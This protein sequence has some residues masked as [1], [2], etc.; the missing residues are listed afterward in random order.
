MKRVKGTIWKGKDCLPTIMFGAKNVSFRR[1]GRVSISYVPFVQELIW[2]F[3]QIPSNSYLVHPPYP[4]IV[5]GCFDTFCQTRKQQQQQQQQQEDSSA[6][7]FTEPK[8]IGQ[9]RC[10]GRA[11]TGLVRLRN[12]AQ[13]ML[14]VLSKNI[15][16]GGLVSLRWA[17]LFFHSI[18]GKS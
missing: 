2:P 7:L 8:T 17:F 13:L 5:V 15:P 10:G 9:L 16:G 4:N 1:G 6:P 12:I 18:A 11:S 14:D 3:K